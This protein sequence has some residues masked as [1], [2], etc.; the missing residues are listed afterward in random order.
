MASVP[1]LAGT[2]LFRNAIFEMLVKLLKQIVVLALVLAGMWAGWKLLGQRMAE[3]TELAM[4]AKR[5]AG[6]ARVVVFPVEKREFRDVIEALGTVQAAESI[7]ISAKVTETVEEL[8]FEDGQK[9]EAGQLLVRLSSQEVLATLEGAKATLAEQEREMARLE[10]LVEDGA[11]PVARLEERGTL[12]ELARRRIQESEA[13]LADRRIEAPF[14]GRLGLRRISPGA[15]VSP[16]TVLATLDQL[17][18]V[19]LDFQVPEVFLA[20]LKPGLK[21]D[22]KSPAWP[23][24]VFTGKV[25]QI[26]SRVDPVT[27]AVTVRAE[28]A[29]EDLALRAGMLM[30]TTVGRRPRQATAIP[31]RALIPLNRRQF[32]LVVSEDGATARQVEIETGARLPG[33]VEVVAGLDVG[34][35]VVTDGFM[36]V[37]DGDPVSIAGTFQEPSQPFNPRTAQGVK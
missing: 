3:R 9:V 31:E 37:R 22:A 33:F 36:G 2:L 10:K 24:R 13:R 15:L 23:G 29:N 18:T 16:G 11:A 6:P 21:I 27:R 20:D 7:E 1:I 8:L 32:V 25:S 17:D 34:A 30:T 19:R 12:A 4:G 28:L 14:A 5:N 26:D 35:K